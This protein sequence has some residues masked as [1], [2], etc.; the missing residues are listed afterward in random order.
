[1]DEYISIKDQY[2]LRHAYRRAALEGLLTGNPSYREDPRLVSKLAEEIGSEAFE[3]AI[4]ADQERL[5]KQR[6]NP[7]LESP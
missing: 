5:Q 6:E 3:Q 2:L 4:Q 7:P 1:M